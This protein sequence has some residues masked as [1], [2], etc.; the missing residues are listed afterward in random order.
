MTN[1]HIHILVTFDSNY[2]QPFKTMLYSLVKNSENENFIIHLLHSTISDEDI[3][4]LYLY[5]RSFDVELIPIKIDRAYFKEAPVS[6]KYPQEMYYRLLSH[7]WLHN[8][9]KKI[10]YLD[11]DILILNSIKPLWNTDLKGKIFAAASHSGI[12]DIVNKVNKVRLGTDNDYF[13]SGVLLIDLDKARKHINREDVFNCV[14]NIKKDLILPDQDV[15]NYLYGSNIIPLDDTVFN[16]DAR[17]LSQYYI[18]TNGKANMDWVIENTI[19]L[20][21]CG[22]QKPWKKTNMY[23]FTSLYKHYM[24]L[25]KRHEEKIKKE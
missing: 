7:L 11:P 1:N 3:S 20:H 5:C 17:Y 18:K 10:L 4:R 19:I 14:E 12:G 25:S 24:V 8:D 23:K 22:K 13:N 16:F 21:F 2:I 15:L 6:Q 9:I